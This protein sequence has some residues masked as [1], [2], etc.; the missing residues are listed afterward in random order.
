M[1]TRKDLKKDINDAV[2]DFAGLCVDYLET[3]TGENTLSVDELIDKAADLLDDTLAKVNRHSHVAAGKETRDYF[4]QVEQQ[5]DG[6]MMK[7]YE[8]FKTTTA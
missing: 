6:G 8:E 2:N 5:F 1:A 3:H 7:L 4:I